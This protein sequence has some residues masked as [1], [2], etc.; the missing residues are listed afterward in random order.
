MNT[1]IEK[2]GRKLDYYAL[3][4]DSNKSELLLKELQTYQNEDGGFGH[5]LEIDIQA[6]VSNMP[7][8]D[9]ALKYIQLIE[10]SHELDLMI[11]NIVSYYES[12]FYEKEHRWYMVEKEV[13]QFPRAIWWNY[14]SRS[15]FGLLNPT[16]EIL[17]FLYQ[18][19]EKLKKINIENEIE[20]MVMTVNTQLSAS[21]GFHDVLSVLRFYRDV[22]YIRENIYKVLFH[23]TQEFLNDT[24]EDYHLRAHQVALIS[25]EF[26]SD[27]FLQKDI[28]KLKRELKQNGYIKCTWQWYQ[29]PKVFEKV[30]PIWN[31]FLTSEALQAIGKFDL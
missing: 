22:P 29:Y 30:K 20:S 23:K 25:K 26:V 31:A 1:Y 2:H 18:H 9:V 11:S 21:K 28:Q 15:S 14:E 13:D 7:S 17:G 8:T 3:I 27:D 4:D 16:P 12:M 5:G 10:P 19:K 24:K 6:P